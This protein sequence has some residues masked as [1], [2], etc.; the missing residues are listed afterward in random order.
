MVDDKGWFV[1]LARPENQV[2]H[3]KLTV[4]MTM[5]R[6]LAVVAT[7]LLLCFQQPSIIPVHAKL[8]DR[9]RIV[10]QRQDSG[11]IANF[12]DNGRAIAGPAY[13]Y[14]MDDS[15]ETS[16]VENRLRADEESREKQ[17]RRKS[18]KLDQ[19]ARG[20]MAVGARLLLTAISIVMSSSSS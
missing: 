11:K 17:R 14:R 5:T 13:R 20:A 7:L 4:R 10:R 9:S 2:Y 18:Q 12:H 16:G 8:A 1:A 6:S 3:R 19:P 15:F